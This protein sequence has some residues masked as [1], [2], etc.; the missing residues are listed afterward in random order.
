M[1]A[2]KNRGHVFLASLAAGE[3]KL[4]CQQKCQGEHAPWGLW[5]SQEGFAEMIAKTGNKQGQKHGVSF[6]KLFLVFTRVKCTFKSL[7]CHDR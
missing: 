1:S 5:K 3:R 6:V 2:D 7:K 4:R